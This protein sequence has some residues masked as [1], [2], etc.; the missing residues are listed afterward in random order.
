MRKGELVTHFW[1]EQPGIG[2]V[3]RFCAIM[4]D[5]PRMCY[6]LWPNGE[7]TL[8]CVKDLEKVKKCP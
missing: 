8:E 3:C 7:K 2:V 6:V 4:R 1:W 5:H